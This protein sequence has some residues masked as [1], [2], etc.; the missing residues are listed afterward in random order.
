MPS[1]PLAS[2]TSA[3]GGSTEEDED[4]LQDSDNL[5]IN[6]EDQLIL[7]RLGMH[8]N[9]LQKQKETLTT[10][11]VR[12]ITLKSKQESTASSTGKGT[13]KALKQEIVNLQS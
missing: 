6:T 10:K 2:C 9:N 7:K 5:D 12:D 13:P 11:R 3:K 4:I 1:T 8:N